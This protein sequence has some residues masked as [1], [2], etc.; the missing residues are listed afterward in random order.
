MANRRMFSQ[1]I[2]D[3][4]AFLDMPLSTQSLYFHLSM[5]AD[6]EGFINNPNKICRMIGAGTDEL[7]LLTAKRF[8]LHFNSGVVVIKHWLI[9]NMI[10]KD[11]MKETLHQEEKSQITIKDNGVYTES[12]QTV[13]IPTVAECQP[14]DNRMTAQVSIGK[15][16]I[17]KDS[18]NNTVDSDESEIACKY[19]DI[20]IHYMSLSLIKHRAYTKEMTKAIKKAES[21]LKCDT[22]HLKTLLDRHML[23]VNAS[24]GCD[25]ETK[26][27]SLVEFFGQKKYQST[28]LICSEYDDPWTEP[29]KEVFMK[30][31]TPSG[32]NFNNFDQRQNTGDDIMSKLAKKNK[33]WG[34]YGQ[35]KNV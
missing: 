25:Y 22:E 12:T 6:D 3:S 24:K 13:E 30:K 33:A 14:S 4:D 1:T 18:I 2:I 29:T 34:N 15:V 21:E 20:F 23:K 16:S 5:R 32:N 28:Q 31:T 19:K 9:H 26:P 8:I 27:R 35:T 10:R 17:D 7:K 11:R